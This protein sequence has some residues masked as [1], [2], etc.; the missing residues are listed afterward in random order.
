MILEAA[1]MTLRAA[2]NRGS[3]RDGLAASDCVK[4]LLEGLCELHKNGVVH[5][6]IKPENIF[7]LESRNRVS[8]RGRPELCARGSHPDRIATH[9]LI[10]AGVEAWRSRRP[11]HAG[12][13]RR[14][15]HCPL[16]IARG[17]QGDGQG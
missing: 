4:Q 9:S 10:A 7:S 12:Q 15:L 11:P 6:D 5:L 1:K 16:R 17:G 13:G 2:L 8:V 3:M 14:T